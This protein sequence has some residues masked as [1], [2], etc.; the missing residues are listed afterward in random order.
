MHF[1]HSSAVLINT[2]I[3]FHCL[4]GD[5]VC[6]QSFATQGDA[7]GGRSIQDAR[8]ILRNQLVSLHD[9]VNDLFLDYS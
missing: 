9:A 2:R 5:R 4:G 1:D 7:T 3:S 6:D 8:I